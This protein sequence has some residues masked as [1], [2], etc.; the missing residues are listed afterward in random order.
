MISESESN[1][2]QS[3][4]NSCQSES[5]SSQSESDSSQSES[6][7]SQRSIHTDSEGRKAKK[8]TSKGDLLHKSIKTGAGIL[9]LI[10]LL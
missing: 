1:S 6:N 4:S 3:E 7:S 5:N 10:H 2:W 9:T 8:G